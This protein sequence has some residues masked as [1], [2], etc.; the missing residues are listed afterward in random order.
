M[1]QVYTLYQERQDALMELQ[2]LSHIPSLEMDVA[3]AR[4]ALT[5]GRAAGVNEAAPVPK[6]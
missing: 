5:L 3:A 2:M 4:Q 1:Y 6:V